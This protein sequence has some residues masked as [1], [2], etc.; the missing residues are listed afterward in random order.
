MNSIQIYESVFLNLYNDHK[1]KKN[2]Q[3]AYYNTS[4]KTAVIV[5]SRFNPLME[6]VIRNFMYFLSPH[7]WNL[8]I[9]SYSG[10]KRQIKS[11]FPNCIFKSIDKKYIYFKDNI[12]NI[13]I[14][15]YNKMFLDT[16]FWKELPGEHIL[17]FQT[18]CIMYKMFDDYFLHYDY[19]GANYYNE[20]S[21]FYGGLNGGCSL[22][23]K[24][25]MIECIINTVKTLFEYK[26]DLLTVITN[27]N[28]LI[29]SDNDLYAELNHLEQ[30][31][32]TNSLLFYKPF[33]SSTS[34]KVM[35][36]QYATNNINE[37]VFFSHSCEL[38]LKSVPDKIHRTFF[39]I[40]TDYNINT[41][42]YHGWNKSYQSIDAAIQIIKQS[43]FLCKYLTPLF[44]SEMQD[45]SCPHIDNIDNIAD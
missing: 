38:L 11:I 12:P 28:K 1:F 36:E 25:A 40:E 39:A 16:D 30:L 4:V 33:Y 10:Y 2:Q 37:D 34:N 6:S 31:A 26:L 13:T 18:D 42:F 20:Q 29:K 14:S 27:H 21:I 3:I 22:R 43:P 35:S 44:I 45:K 24:T 7:E 41:C 5:D 9:V 8:C 17:I 19:C 32:S 23:K 15:S